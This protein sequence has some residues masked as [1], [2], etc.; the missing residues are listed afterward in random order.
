MNEKHILGIDVG[1]TGIKGAIVD[2]ET[3]QLQTERI[4]IL[5]PKPATPEAVITVIRQLMAQLDYSGPVGC[6][7]PAIVQNGIVKTAAN[8]DDS[9]IGVNI[10]ESLGRVTGFPVRAINDADAAGI[11]EMRFGAGRGKNGSVLLITIGTGL[12][13]ALFVD[14]KIVPNSELGH[15]YLKGMVA[16]KYASNIVRKNEELSWEEWGKRLNEYLVHLERIICPDL[17]LLGGGVSK[18]FEKFSEYLNTVAPVLPAESQNE[19]GVI[20]AAVFVNDNLQKEQ[21]ASI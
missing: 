7:F 15:I 5:T 3:G 6:G 9:W 14:Q 2:V 17:F 19:A 13:S 21:R 20:G 11:A 12:G 4:K 18:K 16:E 10:E 8:I 1:G